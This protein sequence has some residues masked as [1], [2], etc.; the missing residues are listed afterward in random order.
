MFNA[1]SISVLKEKLDYEQFLLNEATELLRLHKGQVSP[2]TIEMNDKGTT[3]KVHVV[4]SLAAFHSAELLNKMS[5]LLF[6]ASYKVLDMLIEWIIFENKNNC[7]WRF[8]QKINILNNEKNTLHVPVGFSDIY[9]QIFALYIYLEKYRSAI[10][11][12][13]WGKNVNGDLQFDFI[14]KQSNHITDI[15]SFDLVV[16]FA[17]CISL[18]A[19]TAIS[20]LNTEINK[21][22][23]IKWLMD[24][25]VILHGLPTFNIL[26][27]RFFRVIKNTMVESEPVEVDLDN[28]RKTVETQSS[29]SGYS[30]ELTVTANI[31]NESTVVKWIIPS[32][33]VPF[34]DKLLLDN[35]WDQYKIIL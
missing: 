19:D 1:T 30:Y 15:F 13:K 4:E 18:C 34:Q 6:C 14:D 12:G 35:S 31:K 16:A 21:K 7:P 2:I 27:P 33:A 29:G 23:T 25:M 11:H 32:S 22:M 20:N 28:L 10:I 9:E 8:S 3:L 24:K 26:E 17:E 5:P